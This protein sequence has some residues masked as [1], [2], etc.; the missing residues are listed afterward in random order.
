ML[1]QIKDQLRQ[2]ERDRSI[3]ILLA[4]ES[5]SRAWGFPSPDSDYDV[6]ILYVHEQEWYLRINE[7]KDTIDYFHGELLDISG[8]DMRKALRLLAKSNATP[9]EWSQSPIVY[10]E[11]SGF[12]EELLGLV[13][14]YFQPAATLNHYRGIAHNSI[15]ALSAEGQI[16]LKKLFYVLRPVLAAKWIVE[17]GSVPPMT[18]QALMEPME[19]QGIREQIRELI[20][21]KAQRDE[22]Y[23]HPLS[24][25]L[26]AYLE[27]QFSFLGAVQLP[28]TKAPEL[29]QLNTYFRSLINNH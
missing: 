13:H 16:K 26:K 22:D 12:R 2:L 3:R 10:Q 19:E 5:G 28:A 8:W 18:I 23:L 4:V 17:R 15:K 1:D 6:R 9:A 11:V 20:E 24:T 21:L 7:R 27:E 14:D 29:D 25:S